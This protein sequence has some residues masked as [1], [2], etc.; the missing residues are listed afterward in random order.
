MATI[1][2]QS[3]HQG[4]YGGTHGNMS[5]AIGKF[6]GVAV[7]NDV[8]IL[9]KLPQ[10]LI[11]K[12]VAAGTAV[13]NASTTI[14][15]NAVKEDGSSIALAAALDVNNKITAKDLMPVDTD[16]SSVEIQAV[17]KGGG[18]AAGSNLTVYIEY[19]AVGTK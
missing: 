11:I 15:I 1:Q 19:L 16:F 3:A 6:T 13:A 5:T 17:V 9:G 4:F 10:G 2:G 7:A 8:I 18:I 14:D 12:R